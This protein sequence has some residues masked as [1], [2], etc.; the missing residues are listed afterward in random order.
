MAK[1]K[2]ISFIQIALITSVSTGMVSAQSTVFNILKKELTLAD[3]YYDDRNYRY[4]LKI[5]LRIASRD[6][7]DAEMRI[8]IA[9]CHYLLRQYDEACKWYEQELQSGTLP[10]HDLYNRAEALSALKKYEKAVEAYR[11]YLKHDPENELVIKKIWRLDNIRFLY[12]DSTHYA[13]NPVSFNSRYADIAPVP[14][15]D[16]LI[17]ISNRPTPGII[18]QRD[19]STN[20]AFFR[21]YFA[22]KH[23]DSLINAGGI[24]YASPQPWQMKSDQKFHHGPVAFFGNENEMVFTGTSQTAGEDGERT[25]QLYFAR[26]R[27]GVWE[28]TGAF[29]YNSLSYSLSDPSISS[30]GSVLY[31]TSDMQGGKGGKDLYRSQNRNG[32]WTKPVNLADLN[33]PY[34]EVS[35]YLAANQILY[36]SSN[37][38]AGLGGL[39]IFKVPLVNQ[40]FGEIQNP[41][42]PLNTNGDELA[43]AIDSLN[44]R[45]Y[46]TSNRKSGGSDDDIYEFEIDLQTYPLPINGIVKYKEVSWSDSAHVM[47][48]PNAK[49]SLIDNIRNVQVFECISDSTGNFTLEIP[50]FSTY[51]IKVTGQDNQ[52]TIVSLEIPKH[53]KIDGSKHEIVVVKDPFKASD[54]IGP[55]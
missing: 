16:G 42:Y 39:D 15:S 54:N 40:G 17:F 14:Y 20:A 50:Y 3:N 47:V 53:R 37:G 19:A 34:D 24:Q 43:I 41:G 6:P 2:I 31:F 44:T 23:V 4:A 29:P 46:F 12:E 52:E 55:R 8:R 5:Y 7:S 36:F 35:P 38:H 13:I 51:K 22:K 45:G 11:D 25:L 32:Q 49:L 27:E 30:D 48:M 21:L 1:S 28:E 10:K 26:K 33:T 18:E 9:R